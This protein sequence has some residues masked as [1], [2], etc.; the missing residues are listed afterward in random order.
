S[1]RQNEP[2]RTC[3]AGAILQRAVRPAGGLLPAACPR[4]RLQPARNAPCASRQLR[5]PPTSSGQRKKRAPPAQSVCPGLLAGDARRARSA[6]ARKL[7]SAPPQASAG[8]SR[9]S[10]NRCFARCVRRAN[11]SVL[12]RGARDERASILD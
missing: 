7:S 2:A 11:V 8:S 1:R 12:R 9:D 10:S 5:A 4:T 3:G 6:A